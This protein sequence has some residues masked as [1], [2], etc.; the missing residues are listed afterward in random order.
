MADD[1]RGPEPGESPKARHD[2]EL[3]ELLNELRVALPG[4][5]V[6]FAFL[7]AV[8]F[9]NGWKRVND[10]Q[11]DVFF[12]AFI[13]TAISSA[14]LIAPSAF[15][16]LRWRVEDKGKIVSL[17]NGLS[18]AGLF[19]L[20]ISIVSVVLLVTDFIFDR[21]TALATT[22]AIALVYLVLW[23]GLAAVA[24]LRSRS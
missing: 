17:S 21:T 9:A 20:A 11:R 2:R 14:L 1:D 10:F 18:I 15:H 19:F 3:I 23:Y 24:W 16:R 4:V 8:P 12:V 6:L 13:A 7:L 5:Q 22:I